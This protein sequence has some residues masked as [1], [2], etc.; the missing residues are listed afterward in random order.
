VT[1]AGRSGTDHFGWSYTEEYLERW[2]AVDPLASHRGVDVLRKRG[3][4]VLRELL[5]DGSEP[6]QAFADDLLH[7]YHIA[8]IIGAVAGAGPAGIGYFGVPL[9]PDRPLGARERA[10]VYKLRRQLAMYFQHHLAHARQRDEPP[11]TVREREVAELVLARIHQRGNPVG[12]GRGDRDVGP[13][14]Y[15]RDRP[16]CLPC[17]LADERV[18]A[19][20]AEC[21]TLRSVCALAGIVVGC[22]S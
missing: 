9:G 13:S 8:D 12:A 5:T 6:E 7:R 4:A 17:C 1:S 11:L 22:P 2:W 21:F 18:S 19:V 3:V 16:G 15:A 10:I 14:T 20:P